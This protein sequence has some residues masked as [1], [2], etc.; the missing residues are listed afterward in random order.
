MNELAKE[1]VN[2]ANRIL[3]S[4]LVHESAGVISGYVIPVKKFCEEKGYCSYKQRDG[5]KNV[6]EDVLLQEKIDQHQ[7]KYPTL[8]QSVNESMRSIP[9]K[10]H[11]LERNFNEMERM[12]RNDRQ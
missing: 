2:M 5:M 6:Y 3:Q 11:G 10:H 7:K 4:H 8:V 1:T 9:E 12:L